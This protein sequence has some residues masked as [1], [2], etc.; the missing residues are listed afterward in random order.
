MSY[1]KK[2]WKTGDTIT[3]AA[4][5]NLETGASD[6]ASA[7]AEIQQA[8][9]TYVGEK[10]TRKAAVTITP[11]TANQTIAANQYLTGAQTIKG[12]A[13]LTAGNI[14]KGTSIF[15]VTGTLETGG[16]GTD[17]SDATAEAA[18]IVSGKTAYVA[19]GK[20]T[21]TLGSVTRLM[22]APNSSDD[23]DASV[24][25]VSY[26]PAVGSGFKKIRVKAPSATSASGKKVVDASSV[27]LD[28]EISGSAFGTAV[29]ANVLSGKTFTASPGLKVSGAMQ[30]KAAAT[31]TPG[32]ADQT[33]ASGQYLSG[34]QTIKGDANLVASNIKKGVSIF[35][36]NGTLE[37]GGGSGGATVKTGTFTGDGGAAEVNTGLSSISYFFAYDA[38]QTVHAQGLAVALFDSAHNVSG[39]GVSCSSYSQY[40]K[41]IGISTS[42]VLTVSGG[43]VSFPGASTTNA[44][45][46]N[47][48]YNWV[49]IGEE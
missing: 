11:G 27:E 24:S 37:S 18:D 4:L 19:S 25:E 6:N 41:N 44:P 42:G 35:G 34:A 22:Y 12:D 7:I 43:K 49:A 10:V 47:A 8:L 5:N 17:T 2:T 1:T 38:A 14:R 46:S 3:A 21:G 48:T 36:V 28:I 13:N 31:I 39:L 40:F 45:I 9:P 32:T 16:T 33:I 26:T 23:G 30:S 29:A 15:G 20:V